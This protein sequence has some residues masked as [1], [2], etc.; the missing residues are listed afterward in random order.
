MKNTALGF[1]LLIVTGANTAVWIGQKDRPG[2]SAEN[3]PMENFQV[4]CLA[5][6]FLIWLVA[7]LR[8][9]S[10][11]QKILLAALAL[12]NLSFLVLEVDTRSLNAPLF[13]KLFHGR[14]RDAWLGG[15]W[16]VVGFFVFKNTKLALNEFLRWLKNW[17]GI[18]MVV[19]GVLWIIS[20]LIDKSLLGRKE[21]YRE[22][23]MEVNATLL[24]TLSA[25]IYFWKKKPRLQTGDLPGDF[26]SR[27]PG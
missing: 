2:I 22:E 27:P 4:V 12:F 10:P 23:L 8:S 17:S 18:V 16:L 26:P 20:G 24:M 13:N 15:L 7:S 5:T 11:S 3:G 21:L 19:S 9:K 25:G 14:I 6:S 1:L